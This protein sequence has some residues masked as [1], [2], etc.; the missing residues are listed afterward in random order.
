M[1]AVFRLDKRNIEPGLEHWKLELDT[2]FGSREDAIRYILRK[3]NTNENFIE[4][5]RGYPED[6]KIRLLQDFSFEDRFIT[7]REFF[8]GKNIPGQKTF[9]GMKIKSALLNRSVIISDI[10][11]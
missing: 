1:D 4:L 2:F 10:K 7:E 8:L 11:N 3:H 5:S 6:A 9:I